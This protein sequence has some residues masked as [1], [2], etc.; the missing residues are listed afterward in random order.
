M[1]PAEL[2]QEIWGTSEAGA[3]SRGAREVRR[4]AR[5]LFPADAPGKGRRWFLTQS[6][7]AAIRHTVR[8]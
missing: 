4:V 2:A 8:R 5:K 7:P 3:R 1:T 6:Q